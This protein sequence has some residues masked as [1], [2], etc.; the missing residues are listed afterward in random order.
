VRTEEHRSGLE[1]RFYLRELP[2]I[3]P[4]WTLI[5]GEIMFNLRSALDHLVYQLHVRRFDGDV[6]A[7]IE[8]KSQFPIFDCAAKFRDN[9]LAYIQ[10]LDKPE[11]ETIRLLQPYDTREEGLYVRERLGDLHALHNIDK[12]RQLHLVTSA[13]SAALK[14]EFP[15][16]VGFSQSPHWGN[17]K[18]KSHVET[19]T[20]SKP[21]A[22]MQKHEGAYLAVA[23]KHR[24][25][26]EQLI[27]M[28]LELQTAVAAALKQFIDRFPPVTIDYTVN[29]RFGTAF[30]EP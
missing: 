11:R 29:S 16:E 22:E 4:E 7:D 12:H 15:A 19:W 30:W 26:T 20:F 28:L 23:L 2:A 17:V 6:P 24:D 8:K 3:K 10:A 21:P 25:G 14:H 13:H 27:P 9:G 5:V 1:Y 18:S